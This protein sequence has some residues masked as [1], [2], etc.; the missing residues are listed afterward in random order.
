MTIFNYK[1]NSMWMKFILKK[2]NLIT[3]AEGGVQ[4]DKSKCW[5]I[6]TWGNYFCWWEKGVGDYE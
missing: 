6:I 4:H 2:D 3:Q 1:G 5:N